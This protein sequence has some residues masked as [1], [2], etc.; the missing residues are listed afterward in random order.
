MML[1]D[2]IVARPRS[3]QKK[4]IKFIRAGSSFICYHKTQNAMTQ[5]EF[6]KC[7]RDGFMELPEWVRKKVNN[8]ALLVEDE[9]SAALLRQEGLKPDETLLGY[10]HGIPLARRG[11]GYGIG[12]TLPDT[13]TLYRIPIE[14]AGGGDSARIR[15]IV[16]GTVWHEIGHYLGF[17]EHAIRKAEKNRRRRHAATD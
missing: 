6:E 17:D 16:A 5:K 14:D 4:G 10:Y 11:S 12:A 8:V 7:V 9:P 15:R 2:R 1:K 13:I 3:G